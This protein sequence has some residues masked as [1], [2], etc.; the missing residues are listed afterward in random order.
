MIPDPQINNGTPVVKIA[1]FTCNIKDIRVKNI[2]YI[3]QTDKT[4]GDENFNIRI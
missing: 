4:P 2:F 1:T 3:L